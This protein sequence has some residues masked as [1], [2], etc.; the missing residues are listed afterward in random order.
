MRDVIM[1][2][3]S[4]SGSGLWLIVA[5]LVAQLVVLV[6]CELGKLRALGVFTLTS[7]AGWC[8][9]GRRTILLIMTAKACDPK[10]ERAASPHCSG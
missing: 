8:G 3:L 5:A 6:A 7:I 9:R 4:T 10:A 2:G 1:M